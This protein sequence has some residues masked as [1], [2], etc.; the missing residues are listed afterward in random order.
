[1]KMTGHK[2]QDAL[3]SLEKGSPGMFLSKGCSLA[4]MCG[5]YYWVQ[6]WMQTQFSGVPMLVPDELTSLTGAVLV[7]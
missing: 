2:A 5:K 4:A 6:D 1:M 3:V 7:S